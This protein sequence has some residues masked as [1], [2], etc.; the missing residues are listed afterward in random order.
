M[1]VDGQGVGINASPLL[2]SD[3]GDAG[4]LLQ[5]VRE[6]LDFRNGFPRSVHAQHVYLLDDEDDASGSLLRPLHESL[7]RSPV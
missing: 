6:D 7:V 2:L 3:G 1:P 4:E 5:V